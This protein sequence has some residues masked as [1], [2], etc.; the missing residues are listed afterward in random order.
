MVRDKHIDNLRVL[1]SLAVVLLHVT[2]VCYSFY[3]SQ[4]SI[5]GTI[6]N[7]INVKIKFRNSIY[8]YLFL[9]AEQHYNTNF[10]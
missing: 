2:G 4:E 3:C 7:C 9:N 6:F 1:A 8:K 5:I 10:W